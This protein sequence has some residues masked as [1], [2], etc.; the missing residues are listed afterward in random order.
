MLAFWAIVIGAAA[1]S[2]TLRLLALYWV[3]PLLW[4]HP[5]FLLWGEVSDHFQAPGG[6]RDHVGLFHDALVNGHALYHDVHHR[7]AFI[8]F[9]REREAH[10]H[11][12]SLGLASPETS[13]SAVD[14]VRRIYGR[15]PGEATP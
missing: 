15:A 10:A 4:L 6:T 13:R 2:G 8:P 14:F 1:L 7:Y 12:A 5:T 9:Y 11:L 3:V